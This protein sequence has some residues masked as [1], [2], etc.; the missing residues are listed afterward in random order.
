MLHRNDLN[1]PLRWSFPMT[2]LDDD[3]RQKCFLSTTDY[4]N[5]MQEISSCICK[6]SRK[7]QFEGCE[8]FIMRQKGS[9]SIVVGKRL[10]AWEFF[11]SILYFASECV[12]DLHIQ[13]SVQGRESLKGFAFPCCIIV[14]KESSGTFLVFSNGLCNKFVSGKITLLRL[15]TGKL[16]VRI[17]EQAR[18][19]EIR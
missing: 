19:S 14:G 13:I 17:M 2:K 5:H 15:R 4:A 7:G 8:R 3:S 9:P 10:F 11:S 18:R 6:S 12:V 16:H 1:P